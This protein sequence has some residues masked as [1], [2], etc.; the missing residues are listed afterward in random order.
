MA[1]T[2]TLSDQLNATTDNEP[3]KYPVDDHGKTRH[4]YAKVTQGAAIGDIASQF[5]LFD[6]PAGRVRCLVN[7]LSW[8]FSGVAMGAGRV[9]SLGHRAYYS[10]LNGVPT[11]IAEDLSAFAVGIDGSA[12]APTIR[13]GQGT[14][15]NL[16]FDIYSRAGVRVVATVLI[17]TIPVGSIMETLFPYV[18]D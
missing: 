6:L 16:K 1:Y 18:Y 3:R 13:T 11:L 7:S 9:V 15:T 8:R 17:G 5:E 10:T 4:Q 14:N 12:A 2:L